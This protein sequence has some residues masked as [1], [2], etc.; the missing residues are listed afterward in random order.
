[1]KDDKPSVKKH[2][3]HHEVEKFLPDPIGYEYAEPTV[4]L[5]PEP[6]PVEPKPV[7]AAPEPA[8]AA[9]LPAGTHGDN[10]KKNRRPGKA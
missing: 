3:P 7:V 1:M 8:P 10:V 9:P 2:V 4:P 5:P 6:N